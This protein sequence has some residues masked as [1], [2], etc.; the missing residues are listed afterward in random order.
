[1]LSIKFSFLFRSIL[2]PTIIVELW[3]RCFFIVVNIGVGV[4]VD[5]DGLFRK[6]HVGGFVWFDIRVHVLLLLLLNTTKNDF[7]LLLSIVSS[8]CDHDHI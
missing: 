8:H 1:M 2:G 4:V 5:N 7:L 6:R 3:S